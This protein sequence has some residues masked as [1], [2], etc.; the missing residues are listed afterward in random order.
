MKRAIIVAGLGFG[1]EGKGAATAYLAEK[2]SAGLIVRYNGGANAAH[3]VTAPDFKHHTFRQ[4]GSGTFSGSTTYLGKHVRVDP[5]EVKAE[6]RRLTLLGFRPNQLRAHTDAL[7]VTEYHIYQSAINA[8]MHKRGTTANGVGTTKR[9]AELYP[10]QSLRI[11]DLYGSPDVVYDKVRFIESKLSAGAN[12]WRDI[13]YDLIMAASDCIAPTD[14]SVLNEYD[15]VVF[16]GAQGALLDCE[17]GYKPYVTSS[18]TSFK[19]ALEMI[20][21]GVDSK[22]IGVTRIYATRHGVGPF[23]TESYMLPRDATRE[24]HN[25]AGAAELQGEWR[26]GWLDLNLLRRSVID[27]LGGV[28]SIALSHVDR[29]NTQDNWNIIGAR[30]SDSVRMDDYIEVKSLESLVTQIEAACSA[31]VEVIGCGR[32]T[33]NWSGGIYNDAR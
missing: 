27:I 33:T 2:Y 23:P 7:V 22:R 11:G 24:L 21:E 4:F 32:R 26:T 31:P 3:N 25:R 30:A 17:R 19:H 12:C 9:F 18:D 13:A 1:D 6:S 16:E 10:S 5:L 14:D 20:P 8:A 15:T 29:F 28:D